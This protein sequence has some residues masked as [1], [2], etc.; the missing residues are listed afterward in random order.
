MA[1]RCTYLVKIHNIPEGL[2]VNTYQTCIH[3]VPTRSTRI[4]EVKNSKQVMVHGVE[5]KRQITVAA[6]SA[7]N[8]KVLPFQIIL[9]GLTSKSL[10]PLNDGR[11]ACEEKVGMLLSLPTIGQYLTHARSLLIRFFQA[12]EKHKLKS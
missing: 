7:T 4:W 6:S 1:Q 3:L 12:V 11:I 8:D 2:I 10:P 9:Q 5:D